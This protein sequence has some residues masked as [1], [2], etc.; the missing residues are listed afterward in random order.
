MN[1][2]VAA[3]LVEEILQRVVRRAPSL[4]RVLAGEVDQDGEV[5][6]AECL[7]VVRARERVQ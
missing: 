1:D 3:V 4:G 5:L 6:A 2:V 7:A